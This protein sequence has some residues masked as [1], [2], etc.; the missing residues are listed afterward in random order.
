MTRA[1]AIKTLELMRAEV[2]WEYTMEY[3]AAIDKA[4][5]ALSPSRAKVKW[6]DT[7]ETALVRAE[8]A[9]KDI[10]LVLVMRIL[11]D[12]LEEDVRNERRTDD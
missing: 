7:V 8:T 11:R 6:L 1:E 12:M 2:E 4:I 3:A 9:R 10:D 5:E